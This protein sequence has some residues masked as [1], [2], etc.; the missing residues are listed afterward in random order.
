MI[1][2]ISNSSSVKK[3]ELLFLGTG[4]ADWPY[5]YP[6]AEKQL[7]RGEV[8]GLSSLL[9][10]GNILIDCGPTVLD[11]MKRYEVNPAAIT[12]IVLTHTHDDHYQRDTV[13]AITNSKDTG[14]SRLRFWANPEAL[15][16]VPDS[17]RIEKCPVVIGEA[18]EI[19][20]VEFTGL[21]SNHHVDSSK[22]KCLIY[23]IEG[24]EKNILYAT[25][26]SWL[27]KSTW[28]Y[29]QKKKLDAVI[30]DATIG[31]KVGDYRIFEHNDLSMIRHM[32]ETLKNRKVLKPDAKII[33]TH[34]AR[35]LHP[36]HNQLEEK[37]L[38]EG[39]IPAYDGMSVVMD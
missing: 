22:E 1:T 11:A 34:M 33:L 25:D 31:E 18:F 2:T 10:N 7:A 16:L 39:L 35:T 37:L 6:P 15:K 29:L 32:N 26:S 24:F 28:L 8:R 4:A 17:N 23:L 38:P 20:G 12:D 5:K 3:V 13:L 9:V 21:E 30:W 36:E 19:N 27:L 14:L